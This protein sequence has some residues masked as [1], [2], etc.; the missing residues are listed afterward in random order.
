MV[1]GKLWTQKDR[2][3]NE[4]YLTQERWALIIHPDNHP[5]VGPTLII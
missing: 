5:E 3:G 4:I 1:G 2:F